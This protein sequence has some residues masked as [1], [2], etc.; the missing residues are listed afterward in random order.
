[1]RLFGNNRKADVTVFPQTLQDI[2]HL[3]I[4]QGPQLHASDRT[5]SN[6]N[7]QKLGFADQLDACESPTS[8]SRNI[9]GQRNHLRMLDLRACTREGQRL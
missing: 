1:M 5:C 4:I 9:E 3:R 7:Y 6:T 8:G 2:T